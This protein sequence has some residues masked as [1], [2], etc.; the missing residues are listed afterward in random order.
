M[1]LQQSGY[2]IFVC[3]RETIGHAEKK[4]DGNMRPE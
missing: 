3:M 1:I 2:G 4:A